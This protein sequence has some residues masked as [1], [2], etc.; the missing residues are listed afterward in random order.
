MD[1]FYIAIG[2]VSSVEGFPKTVSCSGKTPVSFSRHVGPLVFELLAKPDRDI[3][4]A[5]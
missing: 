1:S 3:I 2:R 5:Q 4:E